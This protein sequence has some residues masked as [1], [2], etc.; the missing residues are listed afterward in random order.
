MGTTLP[1][2]VDASR[3]SPVE[4][5][6]DTHN[7]S[8]EL[9]VHGRW[10]VAIAAE[11][12]AGVNKCLA[13]HPTAVLVDLRDLGDPGGHS[14]PM[15]LAAYHCGKLRQPPIP[16]MLC[17]PPAATLATRLRQIG[18]Q[19][20]LSV[21]ASM[22]EARAALTSGLR[23]PDRVQQDLPPELD[24]AARAR[25]VLERACLDWDLASLRQRALLV[26]SELVT[27]AVE[28][29]AT[30]MRLTVSRRGAGLYMALQDDDPRLP[31]LLPPPPHDPGTPLLARGQG[32]R[33]VQTAA[34]AWGARRHRSGKIVWA[35]IRG[36]PG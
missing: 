14:A 22:P 26:M 3:E 35:T 29:A 4:V 13:E 32:L 16:L 31:A 23:P 5:V 6:G 21:F 18:A 9:V 25:E 1:Y 36:C 17:I 12:R 7:E 24:S 34:S 15:W 30:D 10:N 27:N 20:F 33:L 11:I 28:H 8:L 19:R 2:W